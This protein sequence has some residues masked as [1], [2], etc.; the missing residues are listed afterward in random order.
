MDKEITYKEFCQSVS[1]WW[2]KEEYTYGAVIFAA[3]R[4]KQEFQKNGITNVNEQYEKFK[5]EKG[6]SF[7]YAGD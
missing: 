1:D 4:A 3:T 2:N 6:E 7:Y 5:Q